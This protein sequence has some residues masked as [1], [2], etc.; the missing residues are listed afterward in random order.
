MRFSRSRW[1]I[2]SLSPALAAFSARAMAALDGVEV[3]QRQLGVDDVDVASGSMRPGDVHD[4]VVLEAAHHVRDRVR[5]ADVRQELVA[6]P[7]ALRGARDEPGDV[8]ELDRGRQDLLGLR[9]VGERLQAR[10]RHRHDA[11]VRI[12]RA[13]R[14][15]R[16]R[17]VLRL[18]ERVEER[19]LADVR[20]PDDAALDA[21]RLFTSLRCAASCIARLGAIAQEYAA[22]PRA[23]HRSPATIASSSSGGA[24]CST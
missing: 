10:I 8:D 23:P 6:E 3:G 24:R 7:L 14:I 17:G 22:A 9:D 4:V 2:A 20:Q 16:G 11:D 13:E 18:R 19:G 1:R 5:L 21:H 12:D 15:V